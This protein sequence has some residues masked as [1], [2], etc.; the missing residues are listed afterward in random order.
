MIMGDY[1]RLYVVRHGSTKWNELGLIQ[2][3]SDIKLSSKGV[4]EA[5]KLKKRLSDVSFAVCITSPLLRA[6]QTAGIITN[7]KTNIIVDDLLTER[8]MG[9][10]EGT[11]HL[12]YERFNYWDYK[13]NVSS[14]GVESVREL[15][16]RTKVFLDKIKRLYSDKTV[17]VVTHGATLRAIHYNV[18]GYDENTDFLEVKPKNGEV[19][20]Y[21][22]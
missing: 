22:L 5:N 15:L 9:T 14:N 19:F 4:E 6:K 10:F 8:N 21:E 16:S 18:I 1:M 12:E 11:D 2:G 20:Y 7:G 3:V 17:L 13:A